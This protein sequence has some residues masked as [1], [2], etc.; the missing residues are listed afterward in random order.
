MHCGGFH[1]PSKSISV[2]LGC[3]V[4]DIDYSILIDLTGPESPRRQ[5]LGV[6]VGELDWVN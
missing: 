2:C 1:L 3:T 6:S 5:A 4:V